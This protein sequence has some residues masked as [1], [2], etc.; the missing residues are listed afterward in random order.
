MNKDKTGKFLKS[1]NSKRA[2]IYAQGWFDGCQKHATAKIENEEST[3]LTHI[4]FGFI[5]GVLFIVLFS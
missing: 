5:I 2:F 1:G 4:C 3:I